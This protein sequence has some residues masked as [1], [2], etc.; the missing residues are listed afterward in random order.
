MTEHLLTPSKVTAWLDCA[1]FLALTNRVEDGVLAAPTT[2]FGSFARLLVDKGLQHEADCL[3]EYAQDGRTILEIPGREPGET[4]AAWVDRVGA[5]FGQGCDVI[6]QMPLVHDG[7]RGVADFLVRVQ[8]VDTGV[9]SYEP[10]DAKLARVEAKPGHILQLCFYAEAIEAVTGVQ[11]QRMHLWLG[12]GRIETLRVDHF[13]P[14]WNRLRA[15]L[16]RSLSAGST[17]VLTIPVPCPHC[18]FC[19]FFNLCTEQWRADDSLT[20]VAGIRE[21]DRLAFERAGVSSLAELAAYRAAI[22][23]IRPERLA[24]LVDQAT[25]QVVAR[26][27]GEEE[28]PPYRMIERTDDPVWGRGFES[29]PEPDDGDVFVDFEGH[30]F[31]RSDTGLFFLFGLLERDEGQWRYRTWWAH[32]EHEERQAAEALILYLARRRAEF[33]GMHIYHYNHT[34]R[35]ALTSLADS[36]PV[37]ESILAGLVETGAFVDLYLVARNS[38]QVG[39]ESYTLKVLERLTDFERS[40]DI[41]KGAGAVVRYERYTQGKQQEDLDAIAVYNEDDVRATLAFRDWLVSHRPA[42]LPWRDAHIEPPP[43]L[44]ELDERVVQLH[45]YGE[46]TD[47]HFLGDL[48]GYWWREWRAYITPKMLKLEGDPA[49]YFDDPEVIADLRPV[50]LENRVNDKGKPLNPAMRFAFEIQALEKFPQAGGRVILRTPEGQ[51]FYPGIHR[52]DKQAGEVEL[53]WGDKLRDSGYLPRTAVL[54]DWV[55]GTPKAKALQ[56]FADAVLTGQ[57]PDDVTMALLRCDSPR[58]TGNGPGGG[59]FSDDLVEMTEWVTQLDR[60]FVAVQ[61]PPGTGKTYC[62]AHLVRSLIRADQR[63]GITAVSHS[64][65]D[66]LLEAIIAVFEEADDRDRLRAVRNAPAGNPRVSGVAYGDNSRCARA[67]FN[68]VGGT[69]WLFSSADMRDAPV[70][71][72][73]VDEAGQMSLADALA[74]SV[75]ARNLVLLGDPLQL[76]QVSQALHT[77]G[78]GRSVLEHIV[79]DDVTLRADRGVFLSKTFRMHPDVCRFISDQ[80]YNGRLSWDDDCARQNTCAGTGLRWLRAEHEGN[81]T[82]SPQE[83]DLIADKLGQLIGT[84]WT[85]HKGE[86]KLLT[87]DDFMI[88]APY[89]DQVRTIR[90]RLKRDPATDAVPVGT[91]DKFQGREAPVVFFSMTTSRGEDITR[92]MN[93]LFSRNR[94]N[95]AVSR[96]RCLAYLVCTDQLLDARARTIE[97]MRLIATL[98]AFVETAAQQV[99]ASVGGMS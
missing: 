86:Q 69:T 49:D 45:A 64:A 92:G 82:S 34:E 68:L 95:V 65:I 43:G 78:S 32:D 88:V 57:E 20:Y 39:A 87:A 74:A 81:T 16:V 22:D 62:A 84:T 77:G 67:G 2:S 7:V 30:P 15:Q 46:G 61:G 29:L 9:V 8:D 37:A 97:D 52:L 17:A 75:S 44:P 11:P 38:V 60:S 3:A 96:A 55:D 59:M 10:V 27:A 31:W 21:T 73:L 91:V 90:E 35:S 5:P 98:N 76:P 72:L 85:N 71:V 13:R 94:L 40:H 23:G 36:H 50:C 41:D 89:N 12:S 56:G 83:A 6:Y 51:R 14:Y 54:D 58:F 26:L 66:N 1:H 18:E 53:L 99:S 24:R 19:E 33:P 47:E 63:V 4:F 93:F 70:D 48:L 80:I 28:P 79:G 25:L 42:E